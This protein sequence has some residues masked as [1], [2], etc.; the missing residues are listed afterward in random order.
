MWGPNLK[1]SLN[2][3]M[4]AVL[5]QFTVN[6][7]VHSLRKREKKKHTH[8]HNKYK[9]LRKNIMIFEIEMVKMEKYKIM[10]EY[11]FP[12]PGFII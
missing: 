3:S 9:S 4:N 7:L 2:A 12:S 5:Q 8:T 11:T 1:C 6:H 10:T